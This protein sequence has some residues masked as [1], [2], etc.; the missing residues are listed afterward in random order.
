MSIY[1]ELFSLRPIVN[2]A[3]NITAYGGSLMA[4]ETVT[5]MD[6]AAEEWVDIPDLL[7]LASEGIAGMLGLGLQTGGDSSERAAGPGTSTAGWLVI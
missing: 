5:A 7:R 6:Q 4:K 2:A 1:R 3:G